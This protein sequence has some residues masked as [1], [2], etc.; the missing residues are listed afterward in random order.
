MAFF[1]NQAVLRKFKTTLREHRALLYVVLVRHM[2]SPTHPPGMRATF[3]RCSNAC[4]A[5]SSI[6]MYTKDTLDEKK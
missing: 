2:L 3:A 1:E 5:I 4:L 6:R